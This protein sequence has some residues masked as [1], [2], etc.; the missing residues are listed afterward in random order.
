M[1]FRMLNEGFLLFSLFFLLS[2][3]P[4]SNLE[5]QVSKGKKLFF[6]EQ[7]RKALPL[8]ETAIR[9]DSSD[10]E[11][12]YY[13]GICHLQN[14]DNEKGLTYIL[15]AVQLNPNVDK[16][17]QA[18]WMGIAH[19]YNYDFKNSQQYFAKYKK[20]LS[21]NDQRHATI[22]KWLNEAQGTKQLSNIKL[23]FWVEQ[24]T[25][26]INSKQSEH[27]PLIS[28]DGKTLI[29]TTRDRNTTGDKEAKDG[30][31]YEDIYRVAINGDS[32]GEPQ[33]ISEQINTKKHDASC[34]L[35]DNDNQMLIY[36]WKNDGDLYVSKK[37]DNNEWGEAVSLPKKTINTRYYESH[38]FISPDGKTLYFA[39]NRGN[40][41]GDLDIYFSNKTKTGEWGEAKKLNRNINSPY[42]D[43]APYITPD[44]KELY[45]SSRGHNS[46]GGFDIFRSV[47]DEKLQIWG[48][49]ENV[50]KPI[51]TSEDDIYLV[52]EKNGQKGYFSS[53]RIFGKGEKDIYR[54]GRI[55]E[56]Q[57]EGTIYSKDTKKPLPQVA[58]NFSNTDFNVK[59]S[60]Y[61]KKDGTYQ[62]SIASD[63]LFSL[64]FGMAPEGSL[65]LVTLHQDTLFIPMAKTPKIVIKRDFYVPEIRKDIQLLGSIKN[66][67][68]LSPMDGK[69]LVRDLESE[70]IIGEIQTKDGKYDSSFELIYGHKIALDFLQEETIYKDITSFKAGDKMVVKENF[71]LGNEGIART[72]IKDNTNDDSTVKS[73]AELISTTVKDETIT[74]LEDNAATKTKTVDTTIKQVENDKSEV[75]GKNTSSKKQP[76][77]ILDNIYFDYNKDKLREQSLKDLDHVVTVMKRFP[78]KTI[79]LNGHADFKGSDEY[80]IKLSRKRTRQVYNYLLDK[81]IDKSRI[82]VAYYGE[83][84]PTAP[85]KLNGKE[86]ST[87]Q[88]LN[89]RVEIVDNSYAD[90]LEGQNQLL[91]LT[92]KNKAGSATLEGEIEVRKNNSTEIVL[93]GK[94]KDGFFEA[95]LKAIAGDIFEITVLENKKTYQNVTT[96]IVPK[97]GVVYREI[98]LGT[99]EN[100]GT[101]K[102]VA[103][104]TTSTLPNLSQ[105]IFY[106]FDK[107]EIKSEAAAE[108]D[109]WIS[110][111]RNNPSKK[112]ELISHTDSRGNK[113]YNTALSKERMEAAANYLIQKGVNAFRIHK[114]LW[115]GED[116]LTNKCK[117]GMPCADKMHKMN[118]RTE[119]RVLEE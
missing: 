106:D 82:N 35:F 55:Y 14:Y 111:L 92:L 105:N 74:L 79:T 86:Q 107:Y 31:F 83:Y 116:Q 57:L 76:T 114:K 6:K 103:Q 51:N 99:K 45:F 93:K 94:S 109:K 7:Y 70:Q 20:S 3:S 5:A 11:A 4:F 37:G 28:E 1:R 39:S 42:D 49:A 12:Y 108:L 16:K 91:A 27:S 61:S 41:K 17:H 19:H 112:I 62:M 101:V 30:G 52:F 38:G 119:I 64:D 72:D 8:F 118:R 98:R 26:S 46:M 67:F 32:W 87:N 65:D 53:S 69:L 56:V 66:L 77:T 22:D 15:K 23:R 2:I 100:D 97:A 43:D 10:A 81:G 54:F 88:Q 71:K 113:A 9:Q 44:G 58:L 110:Y 40:I 59:Y 96:F 102:G 18:Y 78:S 48:P 13:G 89:R 104:T 63:L 33:K 75:L 84:S 25:G 24:L 95:P 117:D 34:Q 50:G 29:Y 73:D 60:I 80:N 85:N 47:W 90:Y 36:R 21:R 68:D 115:F